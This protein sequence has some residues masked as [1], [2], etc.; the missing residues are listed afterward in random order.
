MHE[1]QPLGAMKKEGC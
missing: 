1:K